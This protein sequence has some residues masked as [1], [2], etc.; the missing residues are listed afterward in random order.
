M[1]RTVAIFR[2]A[3]HVF[4]SNEFP[5]E[6]ALYGFD[7]AVCDPAGELV[8]RDK[9]VIGADRCGRG[10]GEGCTGPDIS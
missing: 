6:D 10:S 4:Y 9:I 3:H 8:E 2:E 5:V 7:E 1:K